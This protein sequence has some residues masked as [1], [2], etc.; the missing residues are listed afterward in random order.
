MYQFSDLRTSKTPHPQCPTEIK[1]DPDT[2]DNKF[3]LCMKTF[4]F[5]MLLIFLDTLISIKTTHHTA[6]FLLYLK[7]HTQ[8][9]VERGKNG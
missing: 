4:C 3:K 5:I 2:G 7:K 6:P 9:R 1:T 8:A